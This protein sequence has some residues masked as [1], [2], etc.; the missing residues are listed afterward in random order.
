MVFI[1][2]FIYNCKVEFHFVP[3]PTLLPKCSPNHAETDRA[4]AAEEKYDRPE[5]F[6]LQ[7]RPSEQLTNKFNLP[8]F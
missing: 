4:Y 2:V 6:F 3:Y 5:I 7:R 8:I 1:G